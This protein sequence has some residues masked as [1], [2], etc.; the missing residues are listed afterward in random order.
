M[1]TIILKYSH[2]D[3]RSDALILVVEAVEVQVDSSR[4]QP[5]V[6]RSYVT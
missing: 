3:G 6:R 4:Q 5:A 2:L 1:H